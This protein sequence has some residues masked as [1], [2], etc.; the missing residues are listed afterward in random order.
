M[1]SIRRSSGGGLS[2]YEKPSNEERVEAL[3]ELEGGVGE[4]TYL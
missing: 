2:G 3:N 1:W 4:W